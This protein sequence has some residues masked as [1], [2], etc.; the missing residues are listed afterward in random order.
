MTPKRIIAQDLSFACIASNI[1]PFT[2]SSFSLAFFPSRSL[3]LIL[4][5]PSIKG[6]QFLQ[7]FLNSQNGR[8]GKSREARFTKNNCDKTA[9]TSRGV[10]CTEVVA[11][12]KSRFTRRELINDAWRHVEECEI[13]VLFFFKSKHL[14]KASDLAAR[15]QRVDES[16]EM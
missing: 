5:Y 10:N 12:D 13:F 1:G 16:R 6:H 15:F 7:C 9:C 4:R 8:Q 14:E 2:F 3:R 11:N